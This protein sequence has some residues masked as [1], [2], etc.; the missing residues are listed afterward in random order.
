MRIAEIEHLD[1]VEENGKRRFLTIADVAAIAEVVKRV[2]AGL[3]IV[4]PIMAFMGKS[5]A[6]K[7][8]DV[9]SA[10]GPLVQAVEALDV[11]CIFGRHLKKSVAEVSAVYRGG[12][13]IA[14]TAAVRSGFLV[15]HDPTDETRERRF[16]AHSMTN[17]Y[18]E[19]PTLAYRLAVTA[20]EGIGPTPHIVWEQ[21][22]D[23]VPC[24]GADAVLKAQAKAASNQ[25]DEGSKLSEAVAWLRE[26]LACGGVSANEVFRDGEA[27]GHSRPTL[28]RAKKTLGVNVRKD[29]RGPWVWSLDASTAPNGVLM[30]VTNA[31]LQAI[32]ELENT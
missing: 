6:H 30:Q 14:F 21:A 17:V 24:P 12:G 28:N 31:D 22:D 3:I 32:R 9:R 18:R 20:L 8:Q 4:E 29:G 7:D 5:D 23:A 15:A 11:A 26:E 2:D 16:L 10:L 13:S 19:S 27:N 25:D 1:G